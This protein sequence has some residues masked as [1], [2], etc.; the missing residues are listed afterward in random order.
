MKTPDNKLDNIKTKQVFIVPDGYFDKLPERVQA[1]IAKPEKQAIFKFPAVAKFALAVVT[2]T[3]AVVFW[4][5]NNEVN[6]TQDVHQLLAE[7]PT[8]DIIDY[9]EDADVSL[10]DIIE[11]IDH[12]GSV[13][14]SH[15]NEI[16]TIS[17]ED[18]SIY[19]EDYELTGE[20]L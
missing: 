4:M 12:E 1:R 16:D 2:L 10:S 15:M 17:E 3:I 14:D 5:Q 9:L 8:T 18:M 7:I 13:F 11:S 19:L 20:Y 6:S